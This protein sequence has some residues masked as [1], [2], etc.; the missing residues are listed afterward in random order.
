MHILKI[1][2]RQSPLAL[3]Q[4]EFVSAE[5]KRLHPGLEIELIKMQTQ[6]DIILDSPLSKIGGKGLFVKELEQ[7]LLEGRADIAVHSMKDVPMDFPEGLG[8][9]VI[10]AREAPTDSF[11]SNHYDSLESLPAGAKIGSS[12]LRRQALIRNRFP[13]LIV[14]SLRGNVGTR[15]SKLDAGHYD[16]IILATAGLKR[17]GLHARIRA[18]LP[19]EI[20]LPAIGQGALGIEAR[21]NDSAILALIAP[22]NDPKT[23]I[24]VT[25][26]RAL[27]KRMHGGCQ[28]PIAGFALL[29]NDNLWLRGLVG[30]PA[31]GALVDGEIRGPQQNAVQLGITLADDLLRRGGDKILAK[32]G[33]SNE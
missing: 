23:F 1:A 19:P 33:L 21:V 22:L 30:D 4:A 12:S 10:M 26:E 17:L 8:L 29:E 25:A 14:D 20:S 16:A 2:T 5:L 11:V 7:G 24:C 18:E 6:G 3:W 32:L 9:P 13:H 28:V 31:G 27:N 15:L